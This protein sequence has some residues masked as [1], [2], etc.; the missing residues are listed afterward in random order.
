VIA[1]VAARVHGSLTQFSPTA[2]PEKTAYSSRTS[3]VLELE[4]TRGELAWGPTHTQEP[5]LSEGPA[6]SGV[7]NA[8]AETVGAAPLA[9]V[10]LASTREMVL[11]VH[12]GG[13]EKLPSAKWSE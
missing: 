12:A 8:N 13:A 7:S 4:T 2:G 11:H 9:Y 1:G 6:L 10:V 5:W 3:D